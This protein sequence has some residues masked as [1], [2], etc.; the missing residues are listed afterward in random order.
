MQTLIKEIEEIKNIS[1]YMLQGKQTLEK[2]EVEKFFKSLEKIRYEMFT[3]VKLYNKEQKESKDIIKYTNNSYTAKYKDGILKVHI[4]EVLPKYKN[5]N[6]Y[7]Y[8]NI[9]ESMSEEIQEYNHIF[10]K[11]L[12]LVLIIVHEN[13]VNMDIDNKYVK[14]IVD[15]LVNRNVIHDDNINNMFYLVQGKN[16][17][18]EPYTEVYVM[19]GKDMNSWIE[20]LQNLF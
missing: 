8:K 18:K 4:P 10:G 7:A 17:T 15:A 20:T 9:L 1:E 6:N 16:D 19:K 11:E 12:T 3:K 13:Q 14:P 2:K 5:I